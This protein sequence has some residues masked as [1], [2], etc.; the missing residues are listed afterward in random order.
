MERRHRPVKG[1]L[2]QEQ[3]DQA[4][5]QLWV[6]FR[7]SGDP[8]DLG[9]CFDAL[10][11]SLARFA[12]LL[13]RHETD[14]E[15]ILQ[16]TFLTAIEQRERHQL[17][18]PV[19][20]WMMGILTNHARAVRRRS[21]RAA[22]SQASTELSAAHT[23]HDLGQDDPAGAASAEEVKEQVCANLASLPSIYG[24]VLGP[25]L[26]E[27][28]RPSELAQD[29]SMAPSTVRSRIQRGLELLRRQ[30]PSGLS[31]GA[32]GVVLSEQ[33]RASVREQVL[34]H[35]TAR[36][37]P[38]AASL[39][40][41]QSPPLA[42]AG[43]SSGALLSLAGPL[44]V[45][46]LLL[47][48]AGLGFLLSEPL[49]GALDPAEAGLAPGLPASPISGPAQHSGLGTPSPADPGDQGDAR[50]TAAQRQTPPEP[51]PLL[52]RGNLSFKGAV[53]PTPSPPWNQARLSLH[54]SRALAQP[55][56]VSC[57]A[58]G[59]FELD[60]APLALALGPP[61][62]LR[63]CYL[64]AEHAYAETSRVALVP[65]DDE[66]RL[67]D[68]AQGSGTALEL[69]LV[70]TARPAGVTGIVTGPEGEPLESRAFIVQRSPRGS[71]LGG[72]LQE[73][74]PERTGD[75]ALAVGEPGS[76]L[77]IIEAEQHLPLASA[78]DL[79]LGEY[80]E[81]GLLTLERGVSISGELGAPP[82][83][84]TFPRPGQLARE[85]SE[86]D[87]DGATD[88]GWFVEA[89]WAGVRAQRAL[90]LIWTPSGPLRAGTTIAPDR[91][92][93]FSFNG[94]RP[95][96]YELRL[97]FG[98]NLPLDP[99]LTVWAPASGV[100]LE[101]AC[102][103]GI[104]TVCGQGRLPIPSVRGTLLLPARGLTNLAG[105]ADGR[106]FLTLP[107]TAGAPERAAAR[108]ALSAPDHLAR[109][110]ELPD[111]PFWEQTVYLEAAA[112]DALGN[113]TG[114]DQ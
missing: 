110:I 100:L 15:D 67:A 23:A 32:V 50:S 7:V 30:L 90:G 9:R 108:I 40:P 56:T 33:A 66:R 74:S 20:P 1:E 87:A 21:A 17:D 51:A 8:R 98:R 101:P 55:L 13:A 105:G 16:E 62:L 114:R 61:Q 72:V 11:P 12:G 91:N 106:F 49:R 103:Y 104:L 94:L 48:L 31:L 38:L 22:D 37:S 24:A 107:P 92:G 109:T 58:P 86:D 43:G 46:A 60:L 57:T 65:R 52:L 27:A 77:V 63:D 73:T 39:A 102:N 68:L 26:L 29:L 54:T 5:D 97:R 53:C 36:A 34:T 89:R 71:A 18:R 28:R 19:L 83:A 85:A 84:S 45:A 111:A 3:L 79:G 41:S 14:A 99:P 47:V 80:R 93:A 96:S 75:F 6:A 44:K 81:L 76:F 69:D 88:N 10:Y 95:G 112:G 42:T 64:Q 113:A 35:W 59:P 70:L 78:V 2:N 25:F 4:C 82:T